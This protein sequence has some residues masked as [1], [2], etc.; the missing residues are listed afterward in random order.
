MPRENLLNTPDEPERNFKTLSE[1]GF[2]QMAKMQN[3]SQNELEQIKK[4]QNQSRDKLKQI[5]KMR[6]IKN[7][8]NMSKE[9][10]PIALL[11]SERRLAHFFNN[12]SDNGRIREI[13]KKPE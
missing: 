3:L 7:Y 2:K 12:N 13:K 8:K 1:K 11:E 10:L 6:K 4:I 5:A 9:R